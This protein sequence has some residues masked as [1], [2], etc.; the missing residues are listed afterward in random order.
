ML[1]EARKKKLLHLLSLT[2]IGPQL[3][4]IKKLNTGVVTVHF[5]VEY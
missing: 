5:F 2:L 3:A 1:L 4:K